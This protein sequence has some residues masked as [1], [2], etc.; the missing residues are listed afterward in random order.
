MN[1]ETHEAT[2]GPE[3]WEQTDG[4]VDVFVSG[5]GTGGTIPGSERYLKRMKPEDR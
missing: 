4:T 3:I 1:P 5:V 2:T